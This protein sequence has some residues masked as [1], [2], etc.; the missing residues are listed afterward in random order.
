MLDQ[1]TRSGRIIAAMMRLADDRSWRGISLQD[2]AAESGASL[3]DLHEAFASKTDILAAF[4][5]AADAAILKKMRDEASD[6]DRPRDRLF[7]VIMTRLEVMSPYKPA[8]KRMMEDDQCRYVLSET[9][10]RQALSSQYWMLSAAGIPAEGAKG[11]AR[12]AGLLS[13][14]RTIFSIWLNDDDPGLAKTMAALDRRLRRGETWLIRADA[15]CDRITTILCA[16]NRSGKRDADEAGGATESDTEPDTQ[17]EAKPDT[18]SE[19]EPDTEP[20]AKP[21]AEPEAKPDTEPKAEPD[22]QPEVAADPDP[23]P[24]PG[25]SPRGKPNG[26]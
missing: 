17:P 16:C 20:Q 5:K 2:I 8:L 14:Y 24:T 1:S 9:L 19:A 22:T 4:S 23:T 7:D 11:V 13:L 21:E 12:R 10:M 25:A 15:I 26:G 18:Q 6:E 3:G